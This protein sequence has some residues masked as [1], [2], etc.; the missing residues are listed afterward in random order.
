MLGDK[1]MRDGMCVMPGL[2]KA[3]GIRWEHIKI[4]FLKLLVKF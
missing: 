2:W 3:L 1:G 4:S